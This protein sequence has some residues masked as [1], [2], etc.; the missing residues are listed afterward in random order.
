MNNI[1]SNKLKAIEAAMGQIEKQ[2]GK[3][4][5]MK[6]GE[7]SVLNV[8]SIPT[9]C[10][11]LDIGL[12]IGGVP[13]GRIIEIYGPE[14]SGKTTVALHIVAEAQKKGGAVAFI[15][16]EHAL[17]PSY[18]RK[19]GV[20]T[21][22]L[23]VSQPD[24][25]E[26]GLE[27]AE[28]LVRSGAIDAIVIDS[29][30]ALVPRAEIEGEMGDS[31]VGLQARL[32]SQA[33]RKLAGTINKTNCVAVFINQLR[34]KVGVMFGNPETTPGGRALKFY[35][36]VRMD[37][38]RID[39]IKQGENIVGNRTRVKIIKNK[40]APPFRQAE[41]DIMYNEGISREGNIVDVGVKEEIVQKSG[42]WFSYGDIRLGQ[43]RENAKAYLKENPE[44]ALEI[45]NKIRGK[46][47]LPLITENN[48]SNSAVEE[49]K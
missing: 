25:G 46:H 16:A 27:I 42:A 5:V 8:D 38:R 19:I 39:S 32:M 7:D 23:I 37:V 36:S 12:G 44:I 22:N 28:A 30:A 15:D 17:D 18:A 13:R 48:V 9:G 40:V 24:T 1:D 49:D 14:S 10:L 34:E 3:G 43:G 20:D 31:H 33:L 29:V 4:S 45:E 35:A 21:E 26:Q 47:G 41:F 6:L 2:F 11:D